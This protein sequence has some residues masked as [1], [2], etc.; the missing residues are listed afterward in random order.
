MKLVG[1]CLGL[2]LCALPRQALAQQS[3][4][5]DP[6]EPPGAV[7]ARLSALEPQRRVWYGS[8]TLIADAVSL[9]VTAIGLTLLATSDPGAP[10]YG[11]PMSPWFAVGG[12][13][14]LIGA[15]GYVLAPL[16]IH[17]SHYRNGAALG[18]AG[19]R[20]FLPLLSAGIGSRVG[21]GS[22]KPGLFCD[23]NTGAGVGFIVG[24]L[25]ASAL[26]AGLLAWDN[27]GPTPPADARASFGVAPL[28]SADRKQAGLRVFGAF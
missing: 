1:C 11:E 28:L 21:C 14:A 2:L 5:A 20:V 9:S 18:S 10:D 3:T 23:G 25:G 12:G 6:T 16:G 8:E 19:L 27:A 15:A 4:D 26:D 24:V 22:D 13:L 7:S 17:A